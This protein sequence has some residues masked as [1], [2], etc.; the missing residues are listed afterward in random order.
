LEDNLKQYPNDVEEKPIKDIVSNLLNEIVVLIDME[1]LNNNFDDEP[2]KIDRLSLKLDQIKTPETDNNDQEEGEDDDDEAN[3]YEDDPEEQIYKE[4]KKTL[5]DDRYIIDSCLTHLKQLCFNFIINHL[6]LKPTDNNNNTINDQIHRS[7]NSLFNTNT[8]DNFGMSDNNNNNNSLVFMKLRQDSLNYLASFQILNKL[9]IKMLFFP[10]EPSLTAPKF[11]EQT[12]FSEES[13]S[14]SL[15]ISSFENW[16]KT[17]F[18]IGCTSHFV[19]N[20]NTTSCTKLFEFQWVSLDTLIEL[21]NLSDSVHSH[22]NHGSKKISPLDPP[23]PLS[24]LQQNNNNNKQSICLLQT[25][26]TKQQINLLLNNSKFG[27]LVANMLWSNLNNRRPNCDQQQSQQNET[28]NLVSIGQNY[29]TDKRASILFCQLNELLPNQLCE[30]IIST[31]LKYAQTL[32]AQIDSFKR[33]TRLWHWSR[34]YNSSMIQNIS[35]MNGYGNQFNIMNQD[36]GDLGTADCDLLSIDNELQINSVKHVKLTK[37][38]ERSLLIIIDMLSDEKNTSKT[39]SKLIHDWLHTCITDYND[40]PRIVDILLVSL[41][42]TSTAR[43]SVQNFLGKILSNS[44]HKSKLFNENLNNNSNRNSEDLDDFSYES[45][46]YAISN[47]GGNVKYHV[48]NNFI[49]SSSSVEQTAPTIVQTST[50]ITKLVRNNPN[51]ELPLSV[52]N[53]PSSSMGL[54]INT[55]SSVPVGN[56]SANTPQSNPASAVIIPSPAV[57]FSNISLNEDTDDYESIKS[58][59]QKTNNLPSIV[60][61]SETTKANQQ[62]VVTNEFDR[63]KHNFEVQIEDNNAADAAAEEEDNDDENDD[64]DEDDEDFDSEFLNSEDEYENT[65]CSFNNNTT[66]TTNENDDSSLSQSNELILNNSSENNNAQP[67]NNSVIRST[68]N[69]RKSAEKNSTSDLRI[70]SIRKDKK[71]GMLYFSKKIIL[72]EILYSRTVG[73]NV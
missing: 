13:S 39:M 41:L 5:D 33:F 40:L 70:K 29:A 36:L 25:V 53:Q 52:L 57:V 31:N 20:S 46:V 61:D 24:A 2:L 21:I 43:V 7:F 64:D 37:T 28:D 73:L 68:L 27:N 55:Y 10:R 56:S 6:F 62:Q 26:F 51:V 19:N 9:V 69:S 60:V 50:N 59:K 12:Q 35:S 47:E 45:R 18:V 3:N 38:F 58:L 67:N 11:D 54:H 23:A 16:L 8:F 49:P 32:S 72:L 15:L 4:Y 71:S 34:E 30:D 17:L 44:S 1:S 66:I 42:H 65:I 22:F 63:E 48:N 14:Q